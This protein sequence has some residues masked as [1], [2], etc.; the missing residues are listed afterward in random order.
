MRAVES[1]IY[2]FVR[3]IVRRRF[4][5][6]K[7][8]GIEAMTEE[9]RER[10]RRREERRWE[11]EEVEEVEETILA[12]FFLLRMARHGLRAGDDLA[13]IT[14]RQSHGICKR[15]G[16]PLRWRQKIHQGVGRQQI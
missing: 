13:K 10:T 9:M 5:C 14:L 11:I 2:G 1:R 3:S 7:D 8:R 4:V 16:K 6:W 12:S 15:V